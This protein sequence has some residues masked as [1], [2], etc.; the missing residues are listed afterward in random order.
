MEVA[1]RLQDV[2]FGQQGF[3]RAAASQRIGGL[4]AVIKLGLS[5]GQALAQLRL[6]RIEGLPA[7][8]QGSPLLCQFP[9]LPFELFH[10]LAVSLE[11]RPGALVLRLGRL[12][13]LALG[14][15]LLLDLDGRGSPHHEQAQPGQDKPGAAAS[16]MGQ[17]PVRAVGRR[18]EIRQDDPRM[19]DN[20]NEKA[21]AGKETATK[22]CKSGSIR[23]LRHFAEP[24][25]PD[26]RGGAAR[27]DTLS[28]TWVNAMNLETEQ[29]LSTRLM[30]R[31]DDI[32]RAS[33]SLKAMSHPLR[34]KILC[35]LGDN[36]L[37]VQQ[38]VEA[39]GTTQSNISQHL[40]IL[41]DKGILASRKDANRVFYRVSDARTLRL[42]GM[43]Q[44]VFCP[45]D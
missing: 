5:F 38:I 39:V 6:L 32:E 35:V 26:G 2:A 40:A 1:S 33:R 45:I 16:A 28:W 30:G 8:L 14:F 41:R 42:I 34:L 31:S 17:K 7:L 29:Y 23:P 20:G 11:F 21:G 36:E 9:G 27:S 24:P 18:W 12:D 4:Q 37:S 10:R 15:D 43:M 22:R 19:L 44:E 3:Q 13:C 25:A